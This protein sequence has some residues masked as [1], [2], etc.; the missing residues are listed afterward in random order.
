MKR[1]RHISLSDPWDN[2]KDPI[3]KLLN[4][5]PDHCYMVTNFKI[6]L[7]NRRPEID[8]MV[9][10]YS[11]YLI[12]LTEIEA[13]K[14]SNS[15]WEL[16][17][18]KFIKC[19]YDVINEHSKKMKSVLQQYTEIGY[20]D[21]YVALTNPYVDCKF[22]TGQNRKKKKILPLSQV[23]RKI[24]DNEE[25][26]R[27]N[28]ISGGLDWIRKFVDERLSRLDR[29]TRVPDLPEHEVVS[30]MKRSF[31]DQGVLLK[32]GQTDYR[33]R[34]HYLS[35]LK[36]AD[37]LAEANEY[38]RRLRQFREMQGA[39][40]RHV[41]VFDVEKNDEEHHR[42]WHLFKNQ[43]DDVGLVD[44]LK[45]EPA[46]V[47]KIEVVRGLLRGLEAIHSVG[48]V[49]R[50]ICSDSV[51]VLK[52]DTLA[53]L[54]DFELARDLS[55][56][57]SA[58]TVISG[59][60]SDEVNKGWWSPEAHDDAGKLTEERSDCYSFG[61][62]CRLIFSGLDPASESTAEIEQRLQ[63]EGHLEL[64]ESVQERY[65]QLEAWIS[66]LL[67]V[68]PGERRD[69]KSASLRFSDVINEVQ[70]SR[71]LTALSQGDLVGGRYE[72][73]SD[74]TVSEGS[75]F[76]VLHAWD[77]ELGSDVILKYARNRDSQC[78]AELHKEQDNIIC[79][80]G[81]YG[82]DRIVELAVPRLVQ[83]I[84][85]CLDTGHQFFVRSFVETTRSDVGSGVAVDDFDTWMQCTLRLLAGIKDL[86]QRDWY[87]R[88]V[89]VE[90]VLV[91]A[92][93]PYLIDV[94][95]AI[96]VPPGQNSMEFEGKQEYLPHFLV[97]N[98]GNAEKRKNLR[99]RDLFASLLTS[100]QWLTGEYPW[101]N[102]TVCEE[103]PRPIQRPD[104]VP[105]HHMQVTQFFVRWIG[106]ESVDRWKTQDVHIDDLINGIRELELSTHVERENLLISDTGI[107]FQ[108]YFIQDEQLEFPVTRL[109]SPER[110]NVKD[111]KDKDLVIL[112][113]PDSDSDFAVFE[114]EVKSLQDLPS[115]LCLSWSQH[116]H[117]GH[118]GVAIDVQPE[119]L[120]L[121]PSAQGMRMTR[122]LLRFCERSKRFASSTRGSELSKLACFW[123]GR[124]ERFHWFPLEWSQAVS[125]FP[126]SSGGS[127]DVVGL[128]ALISMVEHLIPEIEL[129]V[130]SIQD[131]H[132]SLDRYVTQLD[133]LDWKSER[134]TLQ[135]HDVGAFYLD[136]LKGSQAPFDGMKLLSESSARGH[137]GEVFRVQRVDQLFVVKIARTELS[138]S[139]RESWQAE[140]DRIDRASELNLSSLASKWDR[141]E[142]SLSGYVVMKAADMS[143][144]EAREGSVFSR[145][146]SS[147]KYVLEQSVNLAHALHKLSEIGIYCTDL[148]QENIMVYSYG[149]ANDPE[150]VLVDFGEGMPRYYSPPEWANSG[151]VIHPPSIGMVYSYSLLLLETILLS[152]GDHEE[153]IAPF[154]SVHHGSTDL[155]SGLDTEDEVWGTDEILE[156]DWASLRESLEK[157]LHQDEQGAWSRGSIED[158]SLKLIAFF[159]KVLNADPDRRKA[160]VADLHQWAGGLKEALEPLGI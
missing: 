81:I 122:E 69:V 137:A 8:V 80:R 87:F 75:P 88:D 126:V 113:Y 46:L 61:L 50:N 145:Y 53:Y 135:W 67:R 40:D 22:D 152:M 45:I 141:P 158:T 124:E 127:K 144:G 95:S 136:L 14:V 25:H 151:R 83:R 129:D 79:L 63:G 6:D 20:V 82:G 35:T 93:M 138:D 150:W 33:F 17:S 9:I 12:D 27:R 34:C 94:G 115:D 31:W 58:V 55:L 143:L 73:K 4:A 1:D 105:Q 139:T 68:N 97:G 132:D 42:V 74:F 36:N 160:K 26:G 128:G 5:L 23:I 148:H 65:P 154:R 57:S 107:I 41:K 125:A 28:P 91:S 13:I 156:T 101:V 116:S 89:S 78:Q 62:L 100:F 84:S 51:R 117:D 108:R 66:A 59:Q 10:G 29:K 18:G 76:R 47:D 111:E 39:Q 109:E 119:D 131:L 70:P 19:K 110:F 90:N 64:P 32:D 134:A 121:Y 86:H 52:N 15:D 44:W 30:E 11:A 24:C 106:K 98:L 120:S 102:G 21:E 130:Q 155:P 77:A 7:K 16:G 103:I 153:L 85:R 159:Q 49:H 104:L 123:A 140:I 149:Y 60:L 96:H 99:V 37:Q 43:E 114:S 112:V 71:D 48:I 38:L 157:Y 118:L 56:S 146:F 72:I 147:M 133:S 92:G 142:A 2:E 3:E 54:S